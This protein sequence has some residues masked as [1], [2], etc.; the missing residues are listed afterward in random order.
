MLGK[1]CL[2]VVVPYSALS[3]EL[4]STISA[5]YAEHV[6]SHVG[7]QSAIPC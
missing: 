4:S 7:L 2:R 3:N 1:F 5:Y 6:V